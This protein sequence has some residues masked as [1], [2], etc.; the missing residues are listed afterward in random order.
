MTTQK[1]LLEAHRKG[2]DEAYHTK[3]PNGKFVL[4]KMV[5]SISLHWCPRRNTG[6]VHKR[7]ISVKRLL[8]GPNVGSI[9]HHNYQGCSFGKCY[10]YDTVDKLLTACIRHDFPG[11]LVGA[12]KERYMNRAS[13]GFD[14]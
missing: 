9:T 13:E 14:K 8:T 3:Y 4:Q 11:E 10:N 7:G 5:D 1:E 6:A 2:L 12:F